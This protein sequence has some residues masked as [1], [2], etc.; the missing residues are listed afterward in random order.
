MP[1]QGGNALD[2]LAVRLMMQNQYTNQGGVESLWMSHTVLGGASTTAPRYYQVDVTGGTVAPATMQ[3]FTHT[4]DTTMNRFMPSIAVDRAG[5]M[6]LGY[7]TSS[8]TSFPAIKYAGRLAADPVNTLPQTEVSLVESADPSADSCEVLAF[9][10]FDF[11]PDPK[12]AHFP[13]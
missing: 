11:R 1:S 4:P 10:T 13:G 9:G 3:A 8:A 5:D 6:A 7:S 2:T 12:A